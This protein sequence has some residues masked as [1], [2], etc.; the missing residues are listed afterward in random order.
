MSKELR[1]FILELKKYRN[2]LSRQVIK[3]LRGQALSGDLTGAKK[4]LNKILG[5]E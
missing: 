5:K 1:I 4:G 3:T 2:R